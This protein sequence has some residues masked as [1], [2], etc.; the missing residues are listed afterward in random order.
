MKGF[1]NILFLALLSIV[2]LLG[3]L[4]LGL[5]ARDVW[6]G[7]AS[8]RWPKATAVVI[9]SVGGENAGNETPSSTVIVAYT[10]NGQEYR[11]STMHFGES[12]GTSDPSHAEMAR[13]R[14]PKGLEISVAYHPQNPAIA[15]VKP[16]FAAEALTKPIL[17]ISLVL[18]GVMFMLAFQSI[19]AQGQ[20]AGMTIMVPRMF[21]A[22]FMLIGVALLTPGV[23]RMVRAV[24]SVN[25]PKAPGV[26]LFSGISSTTSESRDDDGA[27]VETTIFS[28]P[29]VVEYVVDGRKHYSNTRRF[30]HLA[31]SS[32]ANWAQE[33]AQRYPVGAKVQVSYSPADLDQAVLE[34]GISSEAYWLPAAGLVF[35]LF[36]LLVVVVIRF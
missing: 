2:P 31:G 6:R 22:A 15:A 12:T 14:Y 11:T 20:G 32:D 3:L 16:G 4:L 24:E 23:R 26:I 21:G 13:L 1:H 17:G 35:L 10:V 27:A 18:V 33:I 19:T 36:G 9:E 7:A 5:G 8:V 29:L 28:S 25:W 30:G 34:P